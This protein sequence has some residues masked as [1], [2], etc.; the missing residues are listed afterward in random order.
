MTWEVVG[1]VVGDND[2]TRV[3]RHQSRLVTDM[4]NEDELLL[5]PLLDRNSF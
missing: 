3:T 1:N 4:P 2:T 5:V